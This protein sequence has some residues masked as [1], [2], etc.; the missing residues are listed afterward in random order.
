M[1]RNIE[2]LTGK[3]FNNWTVLGFSKRTNSTYWNCKCICG[4]TKDVI[5]ASLVS[6]ESKSCGCVKHIGNF[7]KL[8]LWNKKFGK[9]S[10]IGQSCKTNKNYIW[11]LCICDCGNECEVKGSILKA[12]RKTSCGCSNITKYQN[13]SEMVIKKRIYHDYKTD[14]KE[15]GFTF[16]L[17]FD[18]FCNLINKNCHYCNRSPSNNKKSKY[19][20]ILYNGVDRKDSL[21]G[22]IEGNVLPCCYQC[23]KAKS[24]TPYEDFLNWVKSVYQY[25]VD[26]HEMSS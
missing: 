2:D 18:T 12:G 5:G 23:N 15:R 21:K 6:G 22:Y 25:R 9:L 7:K 20:N 14:A 10:V 4:I 26:Q 11:W 3:Q 24:D 13:N 17:S 16:E 1:P 8:K 19:G